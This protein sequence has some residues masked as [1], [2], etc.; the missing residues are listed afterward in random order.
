MRKILISLQQTGLIPG[1][2]ILENISLALIVVEWATKN[3]IPT[4]L[5]LLD[6]E[7]AFDRVEHKYVWEILEKIGLGGNFLKLVKALLPNFV[8][9][10]HVN[11]RFT[12]E[13]PLSR[14]VRQGFPLSPLLFALSTQPLMPYITHMLNVGDLDEERVA[15][16][17]TICHRLFVENLGIFI[18]E[19][20]ESFHKIQTILKLYEMVVGAKMNLSKIV[21]IL[22]MMIEVPLWIENIGCKVSCPGEI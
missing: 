5:I 7:K 18:L 1:R 14:G 20:K 21:I 15:N 19:N 22:L 10:V 6:S 17:T 11:G 3:R 4:L 8:L 12:E 9:K 13:I 16:N 2:S